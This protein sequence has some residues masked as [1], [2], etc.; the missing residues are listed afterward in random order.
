MSCLV[1]DLAKFV[2]ADGKDRRSEVN[3][4]IDLCEILQVTSK[5]NRDTMI[6]KELWMLE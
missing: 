5:S 6:T 4:F 1:V 3:E 2:V